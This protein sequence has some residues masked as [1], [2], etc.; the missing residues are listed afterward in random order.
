MR[1]TCPISA[2]TFF[3]VAVAIQ[4]LWLSMGF[5]SSWAFRFDMPMVRAS[6]LRQSQR[7]IFWIF[8]VVF[9]VLV[10]CFVITR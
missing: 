5:G 6:R 8:V 10:S 9:A 3:G 2:S 7:E 1:L 4:L